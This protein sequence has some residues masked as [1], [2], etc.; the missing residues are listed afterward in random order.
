M[1]PNLAGLAVL[2]LFGGVVYFMHKKR[3][4]VDSSVECPKMHWICPFFF[5]DPKAQRQE[6][7]NP[8]LDERTKKELEGEV[9]RLEVVKRSLDPEKDVQIMTTLDSQI[10]ELKAKIAQK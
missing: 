5:K 8:L 2:L 10:N 1:L 6:L 9:S 4:Q 7:Q 3:Q